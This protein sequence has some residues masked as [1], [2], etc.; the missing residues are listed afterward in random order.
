MTSLAARANDI[1]VAD[2]KGDERVRGSILE[3]CMRYLE[4]DT[5][6]CWAPEH[7]MND[8]KQDGKTLRELQEEVATGIIAYLT[9]HVW[10][11]VQIKPIL[12]ADSIREHKGRHPRLDLCPARLRARWLRARRLGQQERADCYS[13]RAR[14]V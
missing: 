13:S 14:V 12:D 9:N 4:T 2:A 6:L 7:V 10:P 8:V 11:G 1:V 3:L 5:L